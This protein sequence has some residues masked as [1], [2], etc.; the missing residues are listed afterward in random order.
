MSDDKF[1]DIGHG[2]SFQFADR[3]GSRIGIIFRHPCTP[4]AESDS[5][6]SWV[7]FRERNSAGKGWVVESEEPLTISPS[8]L[9]MTCGHHGHIRAG[10]WE[11]A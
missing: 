6:G 1:T 4:G 9:C 3:G 2:V 8:L 5:Y 10:K 11:P 7:P